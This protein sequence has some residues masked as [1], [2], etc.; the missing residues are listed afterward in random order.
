MRYCRA[1]PRCAGSWASIFCR[2]LELPKTV[3]QHPAG[4]P[5]LLYEVQPA[6][7]ICPQSQGGTVQSTSGLLVNLTCCAAGCGRGQV[8]GLCLSSER[9]AQRSG[10]RH[11]RGGV[12]ESLQSAGTPRQEDPGQGPNLPQSKTGTGLLYVHFRNSR[13]PLNTVRSLH[14]DHHSTSSFIFI[15]I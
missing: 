7:A 1:A 11:R 14:V 13:L 9:P 10:P 15:A 12:E 6:G 5:V 3:C 2:V 8:H 4:S